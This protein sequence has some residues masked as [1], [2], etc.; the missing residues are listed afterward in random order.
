MAMIRPFLPIIGTAART[1]TQNPARRGVKGPLPRLQRDLHWFRVEACGDRCP[2]VRNEDVKA[3]E[4]G[5]DSVEHA[6]D[7]RNLADIRLDHQ[8][9]RTALFEEASGIF[10]G[11]IVLLV[12][13]C[14]S[15]HPLL[16][17]LQ[18]DSAANTA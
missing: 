7:V 10:G 12:V 17:E 13:D 1:R 4:L 6:L 2:G 14:N 11:R 8:R 9:S 15:F 5:L 16:S 18:R 3:P